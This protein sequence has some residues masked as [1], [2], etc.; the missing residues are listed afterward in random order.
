[1]KV[2]PNSRG[3]PMND[4]VCISERD[5]NVRI[6]TS[7]VSTYSQLCHCSCTIGCTALAA[8]TP[9]PR[10]W[11][12]LLPARSLPPEGREHA[13]REALD[14]ADQGQLDADHGGIELGLGGAMM[15]LR[16]GTRCHLIP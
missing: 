11:R 2:W 5:Q 10:P 3:Q 4:K 15:V 1:M 6:A 12:M 14:D 9:S 7:P 13:Q 16:R 8:S